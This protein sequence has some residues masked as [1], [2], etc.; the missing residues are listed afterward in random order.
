[1]KALLLIFSLLLLVSLCVA[2]LSVSINNVTARTESFSGSPLSGFVGINV[3]GI[4]ARFG[5]GPLVGGLSTPFFMMALSEDTGLSPHFILPGI[6]WY[7][8]IGARFCLG[9]MLFQV[10]IGRAIALGKD[11]ELGFTPVRLG[12]GLMLNKHMRIEATAVGIL[13]QLKETLGRIFTVQLGYV[14]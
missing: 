9:K 4:D 8:Y 14:F 13:E 1:M 5:F 6:A 2:S 7:G 10:D 11:L 3:T 12:I